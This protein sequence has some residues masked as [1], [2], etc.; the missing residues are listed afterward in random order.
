MSFW[1][2]LIIQ[3]ALRN[4]CNILFS[5]DMQ[6]GQLIAGKLRIR[7]PFIPKLLEQLKDQ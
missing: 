3:A 1:D 4:D 2:A 7:N 5:E 6:D